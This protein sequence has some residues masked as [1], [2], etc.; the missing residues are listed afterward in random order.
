MGIHRHTLTRLALLPALLTTATAAAEPPPPAPAPVDWPT[1]MAGQDFIYDRLPDA[2]GNG[3]F[4]GN[5]LV[6]AN[7]FS[8]D[9]GQT[10]GWRVGRTDVTFRGNR[11]PIGEWRLSVPGGLHGGTGRLNLWDATFTATLH[12]DAGDIHLDTYTHA[13][14][15]VQV[16]RLAGP[17]VAAATFDFLP[18]P[19][20]NPRPVFQ[21]KPIL[22]ADRNPPPTRRSEGG[23]TV[24][25]QPLTDGH[26]DAIAWQTADAADGSRLAVWSVA[27][28]PTPA[29]ADAAATASVRAAVAA[30]YDRLF[31]SH[32]RWW[33]AY[34]P[35]SFVA[36]PDARLQAFYWAQ[37]YKLAS[38]TRPGRPAID[39]MGPW[40]NATPW[41]MIWWNL[42]LQLT[43]WPVVTANRL[44]L[45]QSL[46]TLLDHGAKALAA[47][48]APF[49][50]DSAYV[51]RASPYD[52]VSPADR[53]AEISD[54]PW[55]LHNEY[56]LY[57]AS[58]DPDLLRN[59]LVPL[60][61]RAVNYYLHLLKADDHG[62]LHLT[63][64][65]SPEYP[66]QPTPDPDCNFD[67]ALLR[68]GCQTLLDADAK[69]GLHDPLAP[70][71]RATL[72]HLTPYPTDANGLRISASVPFARSHRHFSH[73]L[74]IYPLAILNPDQPQ[75]HD[76][77]VKS[78]DHW[79]GMPAALAGYSYTGASSISS[80]MGRGDDA[81]RYLDKLLDR[82]ILPNTLYTETG[83]CIETPLAAAA[84]VNDMLLQSWGGKLRVFPAI[85][86]AWRDVAF[87]HLRG[88]GAFLVSAVRR[89]GRTQWVR[90]TSL[91]GE[92]CV[93]SL[94]MPAPAIDGKPLS[95]A[96]GGGFVVPIGQGQTVTIGTPDAPVAPV[97]ANAGHPNPYGLRARPTSAPAP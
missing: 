60:L 17:G 57:R 40:F 41:P 66:A 92:P 16:I 50:D 81:A 78:L 84:S 96:P 5:G 76:L 77:V 86:T 79:M 15:P 32:A 37:M 56:L 83:P 1:F 36:L 59:H 68:W 7:V 30:G 94:D 24:S 55:A 2:W 95:P 63:R 33:H 22:P 34:W 93:V 6:G 31:A 47:N 97:P 64:G 80:M 48:A 69:L 71:W 82:R 4:T 43:Y 67:L 70:R 62:T 35:E 58:M 87:D 12:T 28:E 39:L 65:Y 19:A 38:A 85:P 72:D 18:A 9:K 23:V 52:C 3:A 54:L 14:Q 25:T 75:N 29:A 13:D 53:S 26:A 46:V 89:D 61:R 8:A 42:N 88:Q 11:I 20:L 44:E 90:I 27:F 10:L 73:L 91:A 51:G 45:G 74:M 49:A 21:K